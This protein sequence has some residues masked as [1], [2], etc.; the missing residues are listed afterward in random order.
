MGEPIDPGYQPP[1][2]FVPPEQWA[3]AQARPAYPYP[4]A[5]PPAYP[6]PP[7]YP[8]GY[9]DRSHEFYFGPWPP[10]A[11]A[12]SHRR[13]NLI[14]V[15]A[16]VAVLVLAGISVYA[17]SSGSNTKSRLAIPQSFDGYMQEHDASSDRV[18]SVIRGSMSGLG[19][20]ATRVFD[21]ASIVVYSSDSD[22]SQKAIVLA[23]PTSTVP[24]DVSAD[25]FASA[26]LQ[27]MGS[28]VS[29]Y[30]VGPRG[31]SLRCGQTSIGVVSES[32][33]AWSDPTTTGM[34]VSV[35]QGGEPLTPQELSAV[36]L[37]LQDQIH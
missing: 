15:V 36:A 16:V 34:I 17:L 13:R 2:P 33:C 24:G 11:P 29:D 18:Q 22:I 32:G 1:M 37:A 30:P 19:G 3:D 9:P 26:L 35:H 8:A 6:Y 12:P 27:Y 31:G 25:E 20:Q 4:P 14:I 7:G 23:L 28:G 21:S 10:V 5:Y